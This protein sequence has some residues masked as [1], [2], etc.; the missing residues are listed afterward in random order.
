MLGKRHLAPGEST[1]LEITYKTYKYAGKFDKSVSIFTGPEGEGKKVIRLRGL[2]DPIPMGV[3]EM[4]PRK[5]PV[6]ILAVDQ[7][8]EVSV[9]IKNTGDADLKISRIVSSKFKTVYFDAKKAGE[10]SI[11]AGQ[12]RSVPFTVKPA[13]PGRFL[14]T[15]LIHSDARNDIGKGYKG[16][17]AGEVR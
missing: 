1:E 11:G 12:E 17:L 5:T 7:E 6:G 16:L 15:I 9:V 2:V 14:D 4:E 13:E 3:I 8:N 10:I